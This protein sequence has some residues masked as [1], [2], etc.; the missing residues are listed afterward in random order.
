MII[1]SEVIQNAM[2]FSL[3]ST[4]NNDAFG[5][6]VAGSSDQFIALYIIKV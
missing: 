3:G 5:R 1:Q 2:Q 6:G 4:K